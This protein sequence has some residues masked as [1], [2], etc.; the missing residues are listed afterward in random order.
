MATSV[1]RGERMSSSTAL[2]SAIGAGEGVASI[3]VTH[4]GSLV[5]PHESWPYWRR[6]KPSSPQSVFHELR[7][8]RLRSEEYDS[9]TTADS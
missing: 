8:C 9:Q 1:G 6:M 3:T 5:R 2:R 4:V 7:T